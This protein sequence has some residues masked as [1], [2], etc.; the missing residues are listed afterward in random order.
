M[1][2]AEVN[3]PDTLAGKVAIA[4]CQNSLTLSRLC[5]LN[6]IWDGVIKGT[7]EGIK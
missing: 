2:T 7:C 4:K 3:F 6:G 5:L 1:Q